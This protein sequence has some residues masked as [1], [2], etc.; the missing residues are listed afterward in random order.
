MIRENGPTRVAVD[1]AELAAIVKSS[2]DAI[3]AM[4]GGGVITSCNPAAARLY[5]YP[6]EQL[7]GQPIELLIPPEHQVAEVAILLR[8]MAGQ[9]AEP[10]R[11]RRICRDGTVVTV[12]STISPILDHDGDIVGAAIA[13]RP[14]SELQ[15]AQD[16][17]EVHVDQHRVEARD[18]THRFE[19]KIDSMRDE[20]KLA[21]ER[22]ET[23]V[24][25][26]RALAQA[27]QARYQVRIAA[28]QAE[29]QSDKDHL[30][31]QQQ[32]SQRLE[33]LGQLAGGIAHDFNNLLAVILNYAAFVAEEL[34]SGPRSDWLAASRDVGQIQRAAERATGLTHQLLAFARREVVQPRVLDLNGIVT[35]VQQ[36][37]HRTIGED[38]VLQ[39]QL[40]EELW[41][42]LADSG[43]MEQ[44]LVNLAVNARDAMGGGGTLI[45]DTANVIV[46]TDFIAAGSALRGGRHV[47]L[48]IS[49]NGTGMP[50]EI[51]DHIFEPFFTTKADGTGTGLGLATVYG[52]VTQAE[53]T[54][55]VQSMPGVGTTFTIMIPVTD[56]IEVPTEA[57][58]AYQRTPQGETVMVVEDEDALR[59]VTERIF[60]R[61]GYRVITAANGA[62]AVALAAGYEGAIHLLVTDVVM[63]NMLG[64]EVAEKVRALRPDIEVL[65]MSGYAQ[66]VLASRGRLDRDVNLIEKP[67]SA[68]ALI[69]KAGQILN[70]HFQ[71]F[72][73]V[74]KRGNAEPSSDTP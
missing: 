48:R 60:N 27:A 15:E 25:Q 35:D 49:D 34:A 30:A 22:F 43:Q 57:A 11:S 16:R 72:H 51:V 2:H 45:I 67:F 28:E 14:V 38:V 65:F 36:L 6:A 40:G 71:G 58:T 10:Y 68:A 70:G 18:A 46:G 63:P 59:E 69:D 12:S 17:F 5:G 44:M 1:R 74:D 56:E 55:S 3:V 21:E 24:D 9:E 53:A 50:A 37:L 20:N 47:R 41:P 52:I 23:H 32:Q 62:E 19:S 8:I 26:E 13:S 39:T 33:V 42:V 61:G 4:T 7:I 54:I 31:A 29:A 64:K 73:T 66:P